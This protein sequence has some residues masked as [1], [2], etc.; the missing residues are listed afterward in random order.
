MLK[1]RVGYYVCI[2]LAL[3]LLTIVGGCAPAAQEPAAPAVKDDA[4][5]KDEVV[6]LKMAT[7]W[8]EHVVWND[9]FW[10]FVERI[11]EKSGGRVKFEF[12]GGPEA[13]P[14]FELIEAVKNGVVD[15]AS[16]PG[17]FYVPQLPEAD[18]MKLSQLT[19]WEERES[20]AYDLFKQLHMD[21]TNTFYLG[22]V[23]PNI[24][25]HLYTNVKLDRPDLRG[26]TVRVTPVYHAMVEAL[27]GAA[28]TM[29]P[30]EVYTAL[31]Q[32]VVD[33]YGW[34][35]IGIADFGWEEVTKYVIDPGFYQVDVNILMNLDTWNR[36]PEDIKQLFSETI[37]EIE[38]MAAEHY[39]N[40]LEEDRR[41]LLDKG[42]EVIRFSA[43]DEALYLQK[44]YEAG[45][46]SVLANSPVYGPQLKELLSK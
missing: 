14:P 8:A 20:G 9:A 40:L 4:P 36:L 12:V 30:G 17:A 28:V 39:G 1:K 2:M 5:A 25:F 41:M 44:T 35:A 6:T 45:W 11:G 46:Q 43:A 42:I 19:P 32:G 38:R 33:A 21:K 31:E 7:A 26:L 22:R 13:F 37:L 15:I 10:M 3:M 29:A 16:I 34:P 24:P 23:T 27:G 18:A